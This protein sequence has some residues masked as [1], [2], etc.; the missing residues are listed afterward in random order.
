MKWMEI[1]GVE[2]AFLTLHIG[3]GG[4]RE[5]DVED[6]TKHKMDSE[7]MFISEQTA[8]IV[9]RAKDREKKVCSVGTS[10]MRA[11]ETAVGT[12]SH[13]KAFDGWTNRFIFP[14]YD[15]SVADAMITN[16]H[17]PYSTLLMTTAA[18]GG[19]DAVLEAYQTALKEKYQFGCYGDA[20]LI[21]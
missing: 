21:L 3:L 1:K 6:L 14:P 17:M 19:Y 9:N 16:F 5:I 15:F 8:D 20:L 7:Q 18:F 12:N 11:I 13:I 10:V 2:A 4:F